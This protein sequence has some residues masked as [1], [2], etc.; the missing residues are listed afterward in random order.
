M[1]W[2]RKFGKDSFDEHQDFEQMMD[3]ERIIN[4]A[5]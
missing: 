2:K 1:R 3:S 4:D 5:C